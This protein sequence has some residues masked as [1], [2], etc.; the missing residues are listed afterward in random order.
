[1]EANRES[2]VRIPMR[3]EARSLNLSNSVAIAVYEALRQQN[4]PDLQDYGKMRV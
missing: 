1:M 3:S 2:C 4:F